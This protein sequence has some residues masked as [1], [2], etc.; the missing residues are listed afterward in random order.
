[1]A[2]PKF[3]SANIA[4][5]TD[6]FGAWVERTNQ[7]VFDM[8]EIVVTA[9]QN[10]QG[11]ATSGNVVITSN[12]YNYDTS[13]YVNS[14]GGILQANTL[15]AFNYLRGGNTSV[16][17]T[18]YI[19]ANT[20]MSNGSVNVA[21]N[22]T[23]NSVT[24][25][26]TFTDIESTTSYVNGTLLQVSSNVHI[27]S[28][29]T[30]TS[31]NSTSMHVTGTLLDVNSTTADFDGTSLTADYNLMTLTGNVIVD[32]D[33]TT[34]T[35]N[36]FTVKS[37][38]SISV[39]DV[40]GDGT[41][42]SLT[43]AGNLVTIDSDESQF[44]ANV[45]FGSSNADTVSVVSEVDT[46][47]SPVSNALSLG[48]T[49][50]RWNLNSNTVNVSNTLSVTG[51]ATFASDVSLGD[52]NT[53]TISINGEVDTNIN[54]EA[55]AQSL[56]L[57]DARW[58]LQAEDIN[59]SKTLLVTGTGDFSNTLD[60]V[61]AGTFSNT[62]NVVGAGTFSN[63]VDAAGL[64]TAAAD[65]NTTTANAS[66]KFNAGA[67]VTIDTTSVFIKGTAA[68]GNVIANSSSL[69]IG[70]NTVNTHISK[71]GI[72]TDGTLAVL[73]A[74]TFS[75][76]IGVTGA[77]TFSNTIGVTN[78]ATFSNTVDATGLVTAS[79]GV[80]TTTA[81]ASVAI[82]V[83]ANVNVTTSKITVG[84]STVN[85][86]ITSNTVVTDGSLDVKEGTTLRSGLAVTGAATLANTVDITGATTVGSTIGVTGAG[87]FSNT[88]GVTGAATLSST[89]DVT[90]AATFANTVDITGQ[91]NATEMN[92]SGNLYVGTAAGN[93]FNSITVGNSSQNSSFTSNGITL[94]GG[95][96]SV[97]ALNSGNTTTTGWINVSG[98]AAIGGNI[99]SALDHTGATAN[100]VSGELYITDTGVTVAP[101]TAFQ[102]NVTITGDLE[103]IGTTGL[104]GNAALALNVATMST[105]AVS[106]NTTLDGQ[107]TIGDGAGV[108]NLYVY[109]VVGNSTVGFIPNGNTVSLGSATE[110]WI[111]SANTGDFSGLITSRNGIK[112]A[113]NTVG[114]A[115][116]DADQRF[117]GY[118][119]SGNFSDTVTLP[120]VTLNSS[121]TIIPSANGIDLG[122]SDK[123]WDVKAVTINTSSDITAAADVDITGEANT[124]TLAVRGLSSFVN[125]ATFS[126]T[127]N[128][129]G[130]FSIHSDIKDDTGN[131]FRVYYANGAIAWPA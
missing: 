120:N 96:L 4:Y 9:Q 22:S 35:A 63:T 110:R 112:P 111:V 29:S 31:I 93:G 124:G 123:R 50:A 51:N 1:M 81:N 106:A 71:G 20:N 83:G 131:A 82:N 77:A 128:V 90:G 66:I 26:G 94:G 59:A 103:V 12:V 58:D 116:G 33:D 126:N 14:T 113:S 105:L 40:N 10:T 80:N 95:F 69:H 79:G 86:A 5:T 24:V 64:V 42:S 104:S 122:A 92:L 99:T 39:L 100:L 55:N 74:G 75:N 2:E 34:I 97:G 89:M 28:S 102:N 32:S 87:T 54:P 23:V 21:S 46:G 36:D 45:T 127:A 114:Q 17:N 108:E 38:S 76:T 52:A 7:I 84:N 44:N 88:I 41:S 78:T 25:K 16:A 30:N 48:L 107:T 72:D 11:G 19:I 8:S 18:L 73:K 37:N 101:N 56:G 68:V 61:G 15:A 117:A 47:V 119:L 70:N 57:A 67:N 125:T 13:A 115:L 60:V 65:L 91:T 43:I 3:R 98:D 27:N 129:V 49:D 130:D 53:D 6:T 109:S 85:T 62:V 121:G 118:F